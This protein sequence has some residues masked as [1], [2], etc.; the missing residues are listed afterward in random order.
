MLTKSGVSEGRLL[1][2]LLRKSSTL[3]EALLL[4]L[5][6]RP[7]SRSLRWKSLKLRV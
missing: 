2:L 5:Y 6:I 4:E 7:K 1:R 3:S